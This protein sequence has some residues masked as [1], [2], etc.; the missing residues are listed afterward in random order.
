MC[1]YVR[2][3]VGEDA[4]AGNVDFWTYEKFLR[5]AEVSLG[6]AARSEK[7]NRMDFRR[8][9]SEV[10]DANMKIDALVAWTQIRSFI[11]GSIQSVKHRRSLTKEEYF[12]LS[13]RENRLEKYLRKIAYDVFESYDAYMKA[14]NLWDDTDRVRSIIIKLFEDQTTMTGMK[15]NRLYVDEIQDFTQSEIA[16]FFMCCDP[17][18]L[19]LAGDSAQSVE[20]GVDFRFEDVRVV[21]YEMVENQRLRPGMFTERVFA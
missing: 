1:S 17:G 12:N 10:F 7:A 11:K 9:K 3:T 5:E 20:E 18:R 8:F 19:F 4:Q 15:R 13:E 14:K 21:A 6:C 2:D 16:M